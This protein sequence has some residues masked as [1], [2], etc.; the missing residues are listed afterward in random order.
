MLLFVIHHLW[1]WSIIGDSGFVVSSILSSA[2]TLLSFHMPT[3]KLGSR[4]AK[5]KS[6]LCFV[7]EKTG[8][9]TSRLT[10]ELYFPP[11]LLRQV[12]FHR[13]GKKKKAH[14]FRLSLERL[15]KV[16]K[17]MSVPLEF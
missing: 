3:G 6:A 16:V 1:I 5:D 12:W 13:W 9:H 10:L 4:P 11:H 15:D 17:D 14:A 2:V 8:D 7:A